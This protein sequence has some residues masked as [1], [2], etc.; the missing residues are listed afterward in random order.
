MS[1]H[2]IENTKT[3]MGASVKITERLSRSF[4]AFTLAAICLG[5][6]AEDTL[7]GEPCG[8][9]E[10]PCLLE[11]GSYHASL[12]ANP[13]GAPVVLW[14]HGYASSGASAIRNESFSGNFNGRGYALISPNGQPSWGKDPKL[15]W[16][17]NDGYQAP[18][19]DV[20]FLQSVLDDAVERYNLDANRVLVAGFSRGG[21]MAWDLACRASEMANA[22][23]GVAGGFWEP[24]FETCEAPVD[25]HHTHG[26]GDS[27]V[28]IE[29]RSGIFQGFEFAQ[30]NVFKAIDIWRK[31]NACPGRADTRETESLPILLQWNECAAGSITLQLTSGGH[32]IPKGWSG[33][34]LDWFE[35][36][37]SGS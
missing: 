36:T 17:V 14:L 37:I 30:G 6:F 20:E 18:R 4:A 25:L 34:V 33:A 1:K 7:A 10:Q 9:V 8:G 15:D 24:M 29:G 3:M 28:P 22:Y 21:S 2:N 23:A 16:G 5:G 31:V 19:D 32:G 35:E 13:E 26:F 27:L 12:P 11:G